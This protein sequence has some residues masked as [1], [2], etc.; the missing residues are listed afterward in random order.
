VN[1]N[2]FK[3][4][5]VTNPSSL[6]LSAFE[7][8]AEKTLTLSRR[9]IIR[10]QGAAVNEVYFLKEG[11]VACSMNVRNGRR[12]IVTVSLPG[13]LLGVPSLC[14]NRAAVT[15][16]ALTPAVVQV[17]SL[18][19][20]AGLF[21]K[22]P[23]LALSMFLISQQERVLLMERLASLGQTKA[24][25][26]LAAF[27]L[28]IH[29]RLKQMHPTLEQSFELPLT[30][31]DLAEIVGLTFVHVNRSLRELDRSGLI[32]RTGKVV[33]LLDLEGLHQLA[34]LPTHQFVRD[35]GWVNAELPRRQAGI[36]APR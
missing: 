35:P 27:L 6:E 24:V 29:E 19:A 12:Q 32:Q 4:L 16:E 11:W 8:L 36:R 7:G 2:P 5:H 20:F 30:Q 18:Q 9:E 13:D 28:H 34:G 1:E 14:L 26:R 3:Q 25:Q 17:I 33:T 22:M 21:M 23:R 31:A 10:A 15:F